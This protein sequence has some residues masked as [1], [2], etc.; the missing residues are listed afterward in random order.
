LNKTPS[1]N[2]SSYDKYISIVLFFP[3]PDHTNSVSSDTISTTPAVII[4]II[5]TS[6]RFGFSSLNKKANTNTKANVDDLHMAL[7]QRQKK[8]NKKKTKKKNR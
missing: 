8:Q 4:I 6:R 1:C 3:Y 2:I 5:P 7:V